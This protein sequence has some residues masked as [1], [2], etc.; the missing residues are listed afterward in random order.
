M[1]PEAF[2][3][4][5][6]FPEDQVVGS[7][8]ISFRDGLR[9]QALHAVPRPANIERRPERLEEDPPIEQMRVISKKPGLELVVK[10][11]ADGLD[12][13][14]RGCPEDAELRRHDLGV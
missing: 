8:R 6:P 4:A 1:D 14:R 5:E 2:H 10:M 12:K 3:A 7:Y 13:E 9:Q 11:V